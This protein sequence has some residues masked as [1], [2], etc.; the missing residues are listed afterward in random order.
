MKNIKILLLCLLSSLSLWGKETPPPLL[1]VGGGYWDA[2]KSHSGG[3]FQ[4]DYRF[5]KYW[6]WTVRPQAVLIAP[7][8]RAFFLG[9]GLGFEWTIVPHVI[10]IP[11]FTPGVYYQGSGRNLGYPV[12]FRSSIEL[13]YEWE[14][15]TRAGIQFYHIS[16]ASLSR[17]NP[18]AN[19]AVVYIGIPLLFKGLW[20][21]K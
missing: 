8:F 9:A 1:T 15:C 13:A 11:S 16:N 18:G 21:Q 14:N 3:A 10:I 19:A 6:F 12:E 7:D 5:G 4:M 2:G 17:R 20:C